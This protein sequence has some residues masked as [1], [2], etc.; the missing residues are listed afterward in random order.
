MRTLYVSFRVL[1]ACDRLLRAS[2]IEIRA[3][4]SGIEHEKLLGAE[5]RAIPSTCSSL[6]ARISGNLAII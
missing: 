1:Y 2:E 4:P 6:V 5:G 3:K